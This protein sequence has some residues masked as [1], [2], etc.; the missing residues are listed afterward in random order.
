[1][2]PEFPI[3]SKRYLLYFS[4]ACPFASRTTAV[5][6]ILGLQDEIELVSVDSEFQRT[7]P[8]TPGD[9][10]TGWVFPSE[11][12]GRFIRPDP[13]FHAKTLRDVYEKCGRS[14][15]KF[16][17]PVLLDKVSKRIVSTESGDIMRMLSEEFRPLA[18]HPI[19]LYPAELRK[20]IDEVNGWTSEFI[21][22]GVYNAGFA[23]SQKV[24][25]HAVHKVFE[26]LDKAEA[27]LAKQRYMCS[28]TRLTEADIRLF[29][30]LI[31]FDHVYNTH[32][33]CNIK[34]IFDYPNLFNFTKDIYQMVPETVDLDEIKK[35]YYKSQ[36]FINPYQIVAVGPAVE[37]DKPHDRDTKFP[38]SNVKSA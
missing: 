24:Y 27:I 29:Q 16:S 10:H 33:K 28:D 26:H 17:T 13:I 19:D 4:L 9:D 31:R 34:R 36:S 6:A 8:D 23:Q 25:E 2:A 35:H 3:E 20:S 15:G 22:N 37:F 1:M 5:V 21:N 12:K 32:F 38:I 7:K 11:K 30:T 14:E 18:K